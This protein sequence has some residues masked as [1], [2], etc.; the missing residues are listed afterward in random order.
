M[1]KNLIILAISLGIIHSYLD[2]LGLENSQTLKYT[3]LNT[4]TY[5]AKDI[6]SLL[7]VHQFLSFDTDKVKDRIRCILMN[8]PHEC[9]KIEVTRCELKGKN[10]EV[11]ERCMIELNKD[12]PVEF[13]K[14]HYLE[15][16]LWTDSLS[17]NYLQYYLRKHNCLQMAGQPK[18]KEY[19]IDYY[20][21]E[22]S[23]AQE[24]LF[25]CYTQY[26]VEFGKEF[27]DSTFS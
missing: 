9:L 5:A 3:S 22:D 8:D 17:P 15:E 18:G 7:P 4:L 19:C 10:S 25:Q 11:Y 26:S 24:N 27:C 14:A 23:W 20:T 21:H 2:I 13:C 16:S 6:P 1:F 12:S